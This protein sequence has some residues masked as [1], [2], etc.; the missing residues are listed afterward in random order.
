[1]PSNLTQ[2]A[3]I[4]KRVYSDD[5]TTEHT[6]RD[7]VFFNMVT[8]KTVFGGEDFRY[9]IKTGNP[10]SI[11]GTFSTAQ[12]QAAAA[13]ATG[14]SKG[15][16]LATQPKLKYG[17]VQIDGPSLE[18]LGGS[19]Q[20]FFDHVTMEFDS[21]LEELGDSLAFDLTHDGSGNR[22]QRA[23]IS[24][25][26]ITL[27]VADDARNFKEGMVI[28]ASPNADGSS[29]RTGSSILTAVDEDNGTI[30]MTLAADITGFANN[31][32][33]FRQGDPATGYDGIALHLPLTAPVFGSD[34]F[35]GI[36]RGS[37][38]R[39]LAGVRVNDPN[40]PIEETAGLIG[41]KIK[42]SGKNVN[43]GCAFWNPIRFWECVRR[44]NAKV[45]YQKAG[46]TADYGF[47][48]I[49]IHTPAGTIKAY[50]DADMPINRQYVG[51]VDSVEIRHLGK[52]PGW[53]TD[54]GGKMSLRVN[55]AD[56]VEARARSHSQTVWR[57]PGEWGVAS[58]PN[59]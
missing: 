12:T 54:D 4:A 1:M 42:Q 24:T 36:D 2:V 44:L 16:Q 19:Y 48:Y 23:S 30:T 18:R 50:S 26:T 31:D 15:K 5:R 20:S 28:I 10:Q 58:L 9:A 22:G 6:L 43:G 46:G 59:T 47:E 53:I 3:F 41:V 49:M 21:T 13:T 38:P 7:H 40:S 45:E 8:R 33:L 55:N 34:S 35:R 39:R 32:F 29:P 25:N 27:S 56:A 37:N 52:F 11:S 14:A 57:V 17:V 51:K